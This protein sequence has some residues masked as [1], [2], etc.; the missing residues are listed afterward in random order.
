[1]NNSSRWYGTAFIAAVSV[2]IACWPGAATLFEFDLAAVA[3]GEWW[4]VFSGHLTHFGFEHLAWD[5][6]VF[7][8]LG[9]MCERR[10][11]R[12][13]FVCLGIAAMLIPASV[14]LMLPEMATY[15]GLSGLDTALFAL[16]GGMML[17]EKLRE[18]SHGWAAMIFVLLLG[19]AAKIAWEFHS[20][21]TMFVDSSSGQFIPVPLAH[22]VGATVGLL[23][24]T[25]LP[26]HFINRLLKLP[27]FA[28]SKVT[29]LCLTKGTSYE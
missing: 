16:L 8:V 3:A 11:R 6:S 25:S 26:K 28:C 19:M 29:C 20:G 10:N 15:R 24:A 7:A 4:R 1:M 14:W 23:V 12:L 27:K 13:T 17:T 18:G 9:L 21:G 2:A 5:A 22:L